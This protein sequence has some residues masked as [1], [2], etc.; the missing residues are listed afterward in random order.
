MSEPEECSFICNAKADIE[1]LEAQLNNNHI[2]TKA[3]IAKLL[4]AILGNGKVGITT[5]VVQLE[6][7]AGGIRKLLWIVLIAIITSSVGLIFT[8]I[9]KGTSAITTQAK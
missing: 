7:W 4:E 9:H 5:R 2:E 3:S 8:S 6:N 1:R